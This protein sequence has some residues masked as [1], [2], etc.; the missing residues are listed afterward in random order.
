MT[1]SRSHSIKKGASA[2]GHIAMII[3]ACP[4]DIS[5]IKNS[6]VPRGRIADDG[7]LH[8]NS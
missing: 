3:A 1:S 6:P 4:V 5:Y 8:F 7:I 2:V